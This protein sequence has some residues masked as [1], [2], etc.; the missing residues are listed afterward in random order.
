VTADNPAPQLLA[1]HRRRRAEISIP[2]R[3]NY[4]NWPGDFLAPAFFYVKV[5]SRFGRFVSSFL[6]PL[7][8]FAQQADAPAY[9]EGDWRK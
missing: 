8:A 1:R 6:V 3:L 2:S 9:N 7:T 4:D 5:P